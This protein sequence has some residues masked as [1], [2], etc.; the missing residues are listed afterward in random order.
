MRGPT[1]DERGLR[2]ARRIVLGLYTGGTSGLVVLLALNG[3][4]DMSDI[5]GVGRARLVAAALLAL[6]LTGCLLLMAA[7]RVGLRPSGPLLFWISY[8]LLAAMAGTAGVQM[9]TMMIAGVW[10]AGCALAEPRRRVPAAAL[11]L[12]VLFGPAALAGPEWP[13]ALGIALF[14]ILYPVF[15]GLFVYYADLCLL[16]LL[17]LIGEAVAGREL[18]ARFA[19]SEE[20]ARIARDIH[21][22]LGH[23]LS[24]IAVRSQLAARL[25]GRDPE[26]ASAEMRGVQQAARDALGEVRAAVA[27]YREADLEA[28][29]R[30]VG[31]VLSAVGARCDLRVDEGVPAGLGGVAAW[32]V[33]EAGTNAIRHARPRRF[34]AAVR[35]LPGA[36]EIEVANDGVPGRKGGACAEGSGLAGMRERAAAVGG[37]LTAGPDGAGGY[38]V[39]AVLP[40]AEPGRAP[41]APGIDE[42]EGTA[43]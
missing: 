34:S 21:D 15:T 18:R 36:V 41:S 27:G 8:A 30:S 10:W 22:L 4:T 28:E 35:R 33:R 2:Q 11:L 29:V 32:L 43:A 9:W 37:T 24:G 1:L 12:P 3:V 14:M 39:R 38:R 16:W 31:D 20:R 5:S 26:A 23:S 25:A 7:D 17:D 6:P 13:F 19:A 40:A 42:R